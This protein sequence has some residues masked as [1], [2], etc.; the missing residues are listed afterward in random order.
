MNFSPLLTSRTPDNGTN[1]FINT[2]K[3]IK[4]AASSNFG[5]VFSVLGKYQFARHLQP[6]F[7][8]KC[9]R[10]SLVAIC[11]NAAAATALP[12]LAL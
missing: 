6:L 1:R 11:A 12:E 9:S 4:M 8:Q 2:I 7:I 10:F 5:N 3:Y